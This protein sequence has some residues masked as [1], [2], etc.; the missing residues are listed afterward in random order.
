MSYHTRTRGF[1]LV[2]MS[3]VIVIIGLLIG[4]VLVGRDMIKTAELNSVL[5]EVATI[6]NDI[7]VF[8]EKYN[9]LPGDM[10]DATTYWGT[11]PDCAS[12]A[13][14][15]SDATCNGNGDGIYGWGGR[16]YFLVWHHLKRSGI[17][18]PRI[19]DYNNCVQ[20]TNA[21]CTT[22]PGFNA[23]SSKYEGGGYTL[24]Y[25]CCDNGQTPETSIWASQRYAAGV[26]QN[27][28]SFGGQG[29][30]GF[31]DGLLVPVRD[32]HYLDAKIDDGMIASG[33]VVASAGATGCAAAI[34]WVPGAHRYGTQLEYAKATFA[35]IDHR[36]AMGFIIDP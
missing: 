16:E 13:T 6:K 26:N 31:M 28:I 15:S 17:M 10:S 34:T 30:Y 14:L 7:G 35:G 2:E 9:A 32:A 5:Q 33:K 36:C 19:T 24:R 27:M 1:S 18:S 23:H 25:H 11:S 20:T 8:K 3:I 4:G 29:W 21:H 12:T 22:I